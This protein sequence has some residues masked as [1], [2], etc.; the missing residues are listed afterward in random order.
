M[1]TADVRGVST[2]GE[3]GQPTVPVMQ[4]TF[5]ASRMTVAASPSNVI[6]FRHLLAESL[7][8]TPRTLPMRSA[9]LAME[10]APS[11]SWGAALAGVARKRTAMMAGVQTRQTKTR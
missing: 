11:G 7:S 4:T 6:T 5:A 9:Q 10:I 1:R 8:E 3:S 2:I